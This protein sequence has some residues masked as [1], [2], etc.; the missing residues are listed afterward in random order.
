VLPAVEGNV[1]M[2]GAAWS[3]GLVN[4]LFSGLLLA[5]NALFVPGQV[6]LDIGNG[7]HHRII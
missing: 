4:V 7:H 6:S 1:L 5:R 3:F 2:T